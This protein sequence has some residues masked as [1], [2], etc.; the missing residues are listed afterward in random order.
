MTEAPRRILFV[1]AFPP[2]GGTVLGG[3]VTSCRIL[4]TSSFASRFDL[5]L[6]DSTQFSNPPPGYAVRLARSAGRFVEFIR[7]FERRRPDAVLLFVAVGLS[8]VEKG[9]M[10]WYARL[11]GV[12]VIMFPRGGSVVDDCRHSA[13]TRLWVRTSFRGAR[14]IICQSESWRQFAVGVL[15]YR[16]SN[17]TVIRNW[18]ATHELLAIGAQRTARQDPC[19]RL[20]FLGWLERS[21]GIFELI[22]A[23]RRLAGNRRFTLDVA[24]E[25]NASAE[26][27]ELAARHDLNGV[28]RFRGWL[29]DAQ[30]LE[31]MTESDVLVLPSWAEG[32]PN[33]MIEAMAAGLAVVVTGVGAIPELIADLRTGLLVEPRNTDALTG[34]LDEIIQNGELRERLARVAHRV[35]VREFEVD[36]AVNRLALQIVGTIA[37]GRERRLSGRSV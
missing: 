17:V 28:V 30:L 32:L 10:A 14:T 20:L 8:I 9:A 3:H 34:A 37:A 5:D 18:T 16:P 36:G 19:V 4:L 11:R 22:E 27:R 6:L 33:A 21:K 2:P 25:G 1:G 23:C 13:F 29:R 24:G 31:A 26:A 7:R 35:A 15:G 12:P